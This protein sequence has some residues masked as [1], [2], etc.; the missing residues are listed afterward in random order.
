M[1]QIYSKAAIFTGFVL[2]YTRQQNQGNRGHGGYGGYGGYRRRGRYGRS[3][4]EDQPTLLQAS[5]V[6][7]DDCAK[8]FVCQLNTIPAEKLSGF[9]REVYED[10][11]KNGTIDVTSEGVEFDL[12]ALTGRLA[13]KDQCARLYGRCSGLSYDKMLQIAAQSTS[14]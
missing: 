3:V 1:T 6:D 8:M 12:A 10:Y 14:H 5:L 2:D 11:G 13:G 7:S 9:E 4:A